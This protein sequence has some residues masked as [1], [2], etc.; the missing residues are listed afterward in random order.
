MS[1]PSDRP[2]KVGDQITHRGVP[3]L[4]YG[5]TDGGQFALVE[6]LED[7]PVEGDNDFAAMVLR[8]PRDPLAPGGSAGDCFKVRL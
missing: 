1:Q 4:V 2:T 8:D 7:T 5:L 3:A 6:L